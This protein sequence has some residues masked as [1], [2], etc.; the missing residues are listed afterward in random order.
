MH[1]FPF[2]KNVLEHV[3]ILQ[4][5][6]LITDPDDPVI[7]ESQCILWSLLMIDLLTDTEMSDPIYLLNAQ[8]QYIIITQ[9][10]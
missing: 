9:S 1:F 5:G 8:N 2:R 7:M 3:A 4:H 10:M 6:I